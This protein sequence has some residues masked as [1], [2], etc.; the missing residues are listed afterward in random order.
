MK[1]FTTEIDE[2]IIKWIRSDNENTTQ[3]A[4]LV[5]K[6]LQQQEKLFAIPVV[7]GRSE[8]L[9]CST[10]KWLKRTDDHCD[11]CFKFEKYEQAT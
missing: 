11:T 10:C 1:D 4:H 9:S 3:C 2:I 8:Q 5:N 7:V 6:F